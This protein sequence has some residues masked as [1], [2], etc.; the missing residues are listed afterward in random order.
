MFLWLIRDDR[1]A[2]TIDWVALGSAIL[3]LGIAVVY[4]IFNSGV[5]S[6][7]AGIN[8]GLAS[9]GI[10]DVGPAPN[11]SGSL[12]AEPGGNTDVVV[13]NDLVLPD[14]TIVPEG[15]KVVDSKSE[16]IDGQVY[17]IVVLETPDG[18]KTAIATT[19][20]SSPRPPTDS[21]VTAGNTVTGEGGTVYDMS[22]YNAAPEDYNL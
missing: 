21:I 11:L 5:A 22:G 6:V 15:S 7:V 2:V 20:G 14:G 17:D 18:Q 13:N 9:V 19:S 8:G 3:L 12:P 4:S 16:N 1:G 10:I